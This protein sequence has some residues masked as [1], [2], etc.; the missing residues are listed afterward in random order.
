MLIN[1]KIEFDSVLLPE[2]N[3]LCSWGELPGSEMK[4][5]VLIT[6]VTFQFGCGEVRVIAKIE[7]EVNEFSIEPPIAWR[8]NSKSCWALE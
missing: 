3:M 8:G 5:K 6:I 2:P 4:I 7:F 1:K